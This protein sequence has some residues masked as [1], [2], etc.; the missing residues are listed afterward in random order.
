MMTR[1]SDLL[2][3]SLE[4]DGVQIITLNQELEFVTGYLEIEK[5]RF[6]DRLKVVF[7]IAPDTLDALVPHLLLQPLVENAV[8][9]GISRR[10]ANGEI[11]I[12]VRHDRRSLCLQVRDNGPG[13]DEYEASQTTTG[14]GLRATRERLQT[15]YGSEQNME[16]RSA[17]GGGVEV[18]LQIPFS[19]EPRPLRYE[20]AHADSGPAA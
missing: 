9:H 19:S 6:E 3:I 16:I 5:V 2:R 13:M 14:L 20:A 18:E 10:S 15:L 11:C 12:A 7:D 1:L 4:N 8:R 17:Q